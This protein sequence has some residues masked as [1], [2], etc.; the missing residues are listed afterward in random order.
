[1]A[2]V[3]ESSARADRTRS[4]WRMAALSL[5]V[6]AFFPPGSSFSA[7]FA[8][9]GI[10]LAIGLLAFQWRRPVSLLLGLALLAVLLS[11]IAARPPSGWYVERGWAVL[12]G[13]GFAVATAL[14]PGRPLF[15]RAATGVAIAGAVLALAGAFQPELLR[16]LDLRIGGQFNQ[17]L[18]FQVARWPTMTEAVR[19]MSAIARL[20]YPALLAL[21]SVSA[22]CVASYVMRRLA[23][24][25]AALPPLR[26]F[27]FHDH[28]AWLL[29]LGLGLFVLP[30]GEIASRVG[31]NLMMFMGAAYVLRGLAVL[32]WMGTVR[33][34]PGRWR[35]LW[36]VAAVVFYPVTLSAA[37][38]I[39]L[40][41]TWLDL[42]S[43]LGV[44]TEE[45]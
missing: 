25:S 19:E 36:A 32:A 33:V 9:V 42:R 39:G 38:V 35:A 45:P 26:S 2:P 34:S 20:V 23:G 41:D 18:E 24:V 27:R 1:V 6:V 44:E 29:I 22:L 17:A 8:Q 14:G 30:A 28:L 12:L 10:P 21:G 37:L 5:A 11:G 31:A 43:R 15:A 3:E 16:G 40:S 13:G 7:M 4:F